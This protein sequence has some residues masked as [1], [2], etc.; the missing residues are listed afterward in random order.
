MIALTATAI[1]IATAPM[2]NIFSMVLVGLLICGSYIC[3][4][5][6]GPT[7]IIDLAVAIVFYNISLLACLVGLH[8]IGR[9]RK[10]ARLV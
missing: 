10:R 7:S 8:L 4:A 5:L 3:A 6:F 9:A 2:R 1:G